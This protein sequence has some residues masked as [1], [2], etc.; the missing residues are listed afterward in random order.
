MSS[1]NRRPILVTGSQRSGSTFVGEMIASHPRVVYV[2]EPFN[3][4]VPRSPV[5]HWYHHVTEEDQE[6]FRAYL[7]PMLIFAYPWWADVLDRPGPRRLAGATWRA[8]RCLVRR[9]LGCRALMKDPSALFSAPWLERE[10]G[11]QVVVLVRHPAA[12]VSSLKRLNWRFW[13]GELVAQPQFLEAHLAAFG[14]EIQRAYHEP[15]DLVGQAVLIWRV[16]H[17]VIRGYQQ[18]HPH[19]TYLR[20][21]DLSTRPVEEFE[22][23][24]GRLGLAFTPQVRRTIEKHTAPENPSEAGERVVHQLKRDSRSN[25]WNWQT[26][27][28]PEEIVRI[29]KGAEDVARFF[30]T[31]DDWREQD[32]ARRSA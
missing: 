24:F 7:R 32:D 8:G 26:R 17:H 14:D 6:R 16:L 2:W 3:K 30:Y 21:E 11:T 22:K 28:T 9:W 31:D 1:P 18:S 12:F 19:W 23:L 20:H 4:Q 5:R 27:L 15:P 29:R 13:F 10:F 25:V